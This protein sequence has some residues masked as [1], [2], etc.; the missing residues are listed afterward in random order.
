[1]VRPTQGPLAGW[2]KVHCGTPTPLATGTPRAGLSFSCYSV[3]LNPPALGCLIWKKATTALP[4]RRS[5]TSVFR[6]PKGSSH[7]RCLL[8]GAAVRSQGVS[9]SSECPFPTVHSTTRTVSRPCWDIFRL[10]RFLQS[11]CSIFNSE[12]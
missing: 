6:D 8:L 4:L 5:V 10:L 12:M 11:P 2:R 1:M 3:L 7:A 9:G